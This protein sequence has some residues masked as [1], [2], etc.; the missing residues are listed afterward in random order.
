LKNYGIVSVC[1]YY[2]TKSIIH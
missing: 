2:L 1:P